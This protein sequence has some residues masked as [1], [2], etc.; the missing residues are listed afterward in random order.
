MKK[1]SAGTAKLSWLKEDEKSSS[2]T[3]CFCLGMRLQGN[4]RCRA[5]KQNLQILLKEESVGT[6]RELLTKS[7]QQLF[8]VYVSYRSVCA[9]KEGEEV[10]LRMAVKN[11]AW[12][13]SQAE[14]S[15]SG[16]HQTGGGH[17]H[18]LKLQTLF[19]RNCFMFLFWKRLLCPCL[20]EGMLSSAYVKFSTIHS[21]ESLHAL[22]K[23]PGSVTIFCHP[24]PAHLQT[25]PLWYMPGLGPLLYRSQQTKLLLESCV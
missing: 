24:A 2:S 16:H 18:C 10:F 19:L 17:R 23:S 9:P 8:V 3:C 5:V 11:R 6:N 12:R 22:S 14:Q 1:G 25:Q 21:V 4:A 15:T 20:Q 7:A 13:E